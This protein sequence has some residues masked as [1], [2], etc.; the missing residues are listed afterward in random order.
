VVDRNGEPL[1]QLTPSG[2]HR[3]TAALVWSNSEK[4]NFGTNRIDRSRQRLHGTRRRLAEG[5][6]SRL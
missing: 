3:T 2:G 5:E 4:G 1:T 6:A